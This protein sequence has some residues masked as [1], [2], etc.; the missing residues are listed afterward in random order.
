V[1]PISLCPSPNPALPDDLDRVRE[2]A[3]VG[4]GHAASALAQLIGTPLWM[5]P[6]E[7]STGETAANWDGSG[8]FLRVEGGPGGCLGIFFA[9]AARGA[10][11]DAVLGGASQQ[12]KAC[13]SALAEVG[14]ILASH[15]L[16]AVSEL[17]GTLILPTPPVTAWRHP[18]KRFAALLERLGLSEAPRIENALVDAR[19]ECRGLLVWVPALI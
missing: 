11:L 10:L 1:N 7:V 4:A 17:A 13:R 9:R 12:P 19:G 16:S 5:R 15:A 18:A 8:V 3:N 6:P 14:N 2:F